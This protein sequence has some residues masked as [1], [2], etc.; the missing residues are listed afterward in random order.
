MEVEANFNIAEKPLKEMHGSG[1]QGNRL[2]LKTQETRAE[3]DR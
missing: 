3:V 1:I 2:K